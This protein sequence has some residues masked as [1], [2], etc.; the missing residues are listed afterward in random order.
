M[1]G[2]VCLLAGGYL[3]FNANDEASKVSGA[4][5]KVGL[6]LAAVWL[7][8]PM[9]KTGSGHTPLIV[10]GI[11]LV[12]LFLAAARPRIFLAGCIIAFLA[13]AA[14]WILKRINKIK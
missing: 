4:L 1:A 7:A 14:N 12:L 8:F 9:L 13:Y 11:L 3:E 2:I 10:F 6:M 5:I